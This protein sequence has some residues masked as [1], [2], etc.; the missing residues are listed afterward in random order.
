M[1][2]VHGHSMLGNNLFGH[3]AT[4]TVMF[5]LVFGLSLLYDSVTKMV[6]K[7]DLSSSLDGRVVKH[8]LFT[9]AKHKEL[10]SFSGESVFL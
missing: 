2:S 10:F 9:L 7:L 6:Q 3:F 4:E 5:C 8:L 1:S